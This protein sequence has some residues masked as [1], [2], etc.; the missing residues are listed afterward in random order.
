M[1]LLITARTL[2]CSINCSSFLVIS[3]STSA[4]NFS[5]HFFPLLFRNLSKKTIIQLIVCRFLLAT[6][7]YYHAITINEVLLAVCAAFAVGEEYDNN[8]TIN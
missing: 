3:A 2:C 8:V 4:L 1:K 7:H 6:I 5:Q